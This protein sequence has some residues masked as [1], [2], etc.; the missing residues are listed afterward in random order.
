[1]S[2][3]TTS[4]NSKELKFDRYSYIV[5]FLLSVKRMTGVGVQAE[6]DFQD[7]RDDIR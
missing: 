6:T 5:I 2:P 7:I 4:G 3:P 1:M